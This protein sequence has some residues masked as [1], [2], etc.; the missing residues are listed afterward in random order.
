MLLKQKDICNNQ[1][2]LGS[3]GTMILGGGCDTVPFEFNTLYKDFLVG[4]GVVVVSDN[5][6]MSRRYFF[7]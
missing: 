3:L 4:T 1:G 6:Q 2:S 5:S 7:R